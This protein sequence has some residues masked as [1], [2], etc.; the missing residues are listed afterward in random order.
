MG[1]KQDRNGDI[2]ERDERSAWKRG[3]LARQAT[4]DG[5]A[6]HWTIARGIETIS[7]GVSA[8]IWSLELMRVSWPFPGRPC[9]D[10]WQGNRYEPELQPCRT[11][12][13]WLSIFDAPT[14]PTAVYVA[15]LS[16]S[17]CCGTFVR[18]SVLLD[19]GP[20]LRYVCIS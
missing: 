15:Y 7:V 9:Y 14:I 17:L 20:S 3:R 10:V 12:S 16:L 18:Q 11:L 6:F 19:A 5:R 4:D 13:V 8:T 2:T 1:Y